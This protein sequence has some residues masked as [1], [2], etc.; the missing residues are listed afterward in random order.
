MTACPATPPQP[1]KHSYLGVVVPFVVICLVWGSTWLVIKDQVSTIP[2]PWTAT[3]RFAVAAPGMALLALYRRES[4]RIPAAAQRVAMAVG[5]ALF[6][7]NFQFVYQA[8]KHV[9][10]GVVAVT[11]ALLILPNAVFARIF[12]G[13][14]VS[15]GFV[16]GSALALIGIA[17][18]VLHEY[19]MAP[20]DSEVIFGIGLCF[21]ALL[22]ASA[23]NV[24]QA[25][26][27]AR[28]APAAPLLAWAMFWGTVCNFAVSWTLAGPPVIDPRPQALAGVA[29]LA[30]VGSVLTFPL[31]FNLLHRI[32]P[33]KAAFHAVIVPVVAMLLSTLF[34]GYQW[35]L[36]A[37]TGAAL[38]IFGVLIAL[39]SR[40]M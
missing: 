36:L 27:G 21:G 35:T 20:P 28:T 10:S 31:Y 8:E 12:L 6:C 32:G 37:A 3:W 1:A 11:F 18:L 34:E 29:Y 15:L 19:R 26:A 13:I 9:T 40:R 4:L 25:S 38:A 5:A 2:A 16:A 33:G 39:S 22:V 24:V 30:L 14:R 7:L 23:A 17:L